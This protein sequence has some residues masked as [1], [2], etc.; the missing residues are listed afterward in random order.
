MHIQQNTTENLAVDLNREGPIDL[1][2]VFYMGVADLKIM[3]VDGVS[4]QP[5]AKQ[6]CRHYNNRNS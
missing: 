2:A 1:H 3:P 6:R 5:T 4:L